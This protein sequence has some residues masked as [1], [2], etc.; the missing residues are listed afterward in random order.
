[1]PST[2]YKLDDSQ[3]YNLTCEVNLM[4]SV[5]QMKNGGSRACRA[6]PGSDFR[7]PVLPLLVYFRTEQAAPFTCVFPEGGSVPGM[8]LAS[9]L[10]LAMKQTKESELCVW[11]DQSAK[12]GSEYKQQSA[13]VPSKQQQHGSC[14]V[15]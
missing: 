11:H 1:M 8:G 9:Q 3:L 15:K 14:G 12:C 6:R 13:D 5:I 2:W 10:F 7:A 4:I